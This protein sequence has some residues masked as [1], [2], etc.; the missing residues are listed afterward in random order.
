MR[1]LGSTHC[2]VSHFIGDYGKSLPRFTGPGSLDRRVQCK[3]VGLKSVPGRGSG[4]FISF[5]G[6]LRKKILGQDQDGTEAQPKRQLCRL[7]RT[8][9][10]GA[11]PIAAEKAFLRSPR[12]TSN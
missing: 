11:T 2:Q 10:K 5:A 1:C 8:W 7:S 12:K 4:R 6:H 9:G 3:E